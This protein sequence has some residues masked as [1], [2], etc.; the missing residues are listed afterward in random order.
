[1][2]NI[3][4]AKHNFQ[5]FTNEIDKYIRED[6]SESDTRSKVI[7]SLVIKVLG[8]TEENIKREEYS[9]AGYY[10]YKISIPGLSFIIEAKRQ[11]KELSIPT[12]H[13]KASIKSLY[14][15]NREIIDQIRG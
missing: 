10:D 8:W 4:E 5:A 6:L 13:K 12:N 1:M 11:F 9:V 3:D 7:D 2:T 14:S 15:E